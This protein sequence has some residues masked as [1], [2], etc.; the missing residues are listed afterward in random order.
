MIFAA[1][2]SRMLQVAARF[3]DT[4]VLAV[5]TRPRLAAATPTAVSVAAQIAAVRGARPAQ[6]PMPGFHR[7]IR[8]LSTN[9][10]DDPDGDWWT[11][12][13]SPGQIADA[14]H[15]RADAGVDYLSVCTED[16]HLLEWLASHVLPWCEE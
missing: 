13:G 2:T 14:L 1:G 15:R 8:D 7:Q 6:M 5:P 16:L 12:G 3:A 9:P 11:M 10:P 4:V